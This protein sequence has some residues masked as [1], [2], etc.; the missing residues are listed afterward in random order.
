MSF[1]TPK[2]A[3]ER[4]SADKQTQSKPKSKLKK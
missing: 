1:G 3:S 2:I 4:V